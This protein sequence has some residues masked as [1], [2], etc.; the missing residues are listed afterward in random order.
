MKEL[1]EDHVFLECVLFGHLEGVVLVE[2]GC[3][4]VGSKRQVAAGA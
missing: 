1:Q 2:D 3:S 4:G